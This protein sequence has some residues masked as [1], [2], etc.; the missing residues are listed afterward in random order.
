[1]KFNRKFGNLFA[2]ALL[3]TLSFSSCSRGYGCPYD[4]SFSDGLVNVLGSF[5]KGLIYL[6]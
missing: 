1:M 3:V 5:V 4:F 2:L 6:F